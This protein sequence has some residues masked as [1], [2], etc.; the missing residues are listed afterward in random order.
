MRRREFI[1]GIAVWPVAARAQQPARMRRVGVLTPWPN[2]D[3]E[4]L[5]RVRSFTQALQQLGW[6]E[7]QN[8]QIEYR[9][10]NGNADL[11]R[12]HAAEL[13]AFAPDV[14]LGLSSA[15]AA[16]LLEASRT[17]PIVFAGVADPV[18]AGYVESL[19]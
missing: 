18:A 12:K 7:E 2:T 14:I 15:A 8:V 13:V 10:S 11:A 17:V 9:W 3:A 1:T 19:T 5:I 16:P 4:A 6:T